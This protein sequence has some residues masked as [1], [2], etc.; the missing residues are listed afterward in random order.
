MQ[1]LFFAIGGIDFFLDE[2]PGLFYR[3]LS[4][5]WGNG[6]GEEV[7]VEGSLR[8]AHGKIRLKVKG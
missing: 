1:Y 2:V 5:I 4:I 7:K 3:M 8:C 6:I